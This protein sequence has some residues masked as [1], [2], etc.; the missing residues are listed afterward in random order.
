M[1]PS[2]PFTAFLPELVLLLGALVVFLI[3]LGES[4]VRQARAA[5]LLISV[6]AVG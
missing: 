6:G 1:T 5:A 2:S 3:T 4:R